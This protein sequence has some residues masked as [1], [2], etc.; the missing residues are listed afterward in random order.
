MGT[1]DPRMSKNENL[2]S[3]YRFTAA[4]TEELRHRP[5]YR[6]ATEFAIDSGRPDIIQPDPMT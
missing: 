4:L 6:S 2:V 3:S 1:M 5:W